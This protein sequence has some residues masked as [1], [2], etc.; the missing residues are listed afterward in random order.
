M[1]IRHKGLLAGVVAFLLAIAV[2]TTH[3]L[4]VTHNNCI[5]EDVGG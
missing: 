1:V 5:D 4:G 2:S 3:R